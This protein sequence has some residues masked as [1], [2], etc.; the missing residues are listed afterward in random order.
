SISAAK[1]EST[2]TVDLSVLTSTVRPSCRCSARYVTVKA[3]VARVS[4]TVYGPMDA[5]AGGLRRSA[6][7]GAGS[8]MGDATRGSAREERAPRHRLRLWLAEDL[9]HG[10]GDVADAAAALQRGALVGL[11]HVEE[12]HRVGGVGRVRA[13]LLVLHL[14]A[15]AVVGGEQQ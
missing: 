14:L 8:V 2:A 10:R 13:A 12:R 15:V 6:G 1:G 4:T 11:V 5:G 7:S 9:E 3:P